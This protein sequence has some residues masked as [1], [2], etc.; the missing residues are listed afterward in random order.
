MESIPARQA[1]L[2]VVAVVHRQANLLEVVLALRAGRGLAD[3]LDGGQQ[4]ADEDGDD[5]D[6]HQQFDERE[7]GS[8]AHVISPG[9]SEM[10]KYR[11]KGQRY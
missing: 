4:Q 5:R 7:P 1:F 9:T 2:D 8:T 6:D 3:F 11:P 10:K